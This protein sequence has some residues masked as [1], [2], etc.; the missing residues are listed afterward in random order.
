MINLSDETYHA[1]EDLREKRETFDEA[2]KRLLRVFSTLRN[3]SDILG[4]G[5]YLKGEPPYDTKA[6]K[7]ADR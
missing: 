5:H 7:D 1:L 6:P 2:V 3:V 4:P